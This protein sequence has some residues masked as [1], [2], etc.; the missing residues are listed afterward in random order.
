MAKW[1]VDRNS[2]PGSVHDKSNNDDKATVLQSGPWAAAIQEA[3]SYAFVVD[4][5]CCDRDVDSNKSAGVSRRSHRKKNNLALATPLER[6]DCS[7][8]YLDS[9]R[10]LL[11]QQDNWEW[12]PYPC[13]PPSFHPLQ[14][15]IIDDQNT[16]FSASFNKEN[17]EDA[18]HNS[19]QKITFHSSKSSPH[20][21]QKTK[22]SV[23][24][25]NLSLSQGNN[26]AY[27]RNRFAGF[28]SDS[29]SDRDEGDDPVE[30]LEPLNTLMDQD[31]S[32]EAN[33]YEPSHDQEHQQ[34]QPLETMDTI[35]LLI[36]LKA[37]Q[38]D[39]YAKKARLMATARYWLPGAEALHSSSVV[40]TQ[41]LELADATISKTL[42]L[43]TST[44]TSTVGSKNKKKNDVR[45]RQLERDADII[46]VSTSY[47]IYEKERYLKVAHS[48]ALKLEHI[49][50]PMWERR[51]QARQRMGQ[52]WNKNPNP[53]GYF[54][55]M[56]KQYEMELYALEQALKSLEE[57]QANASS[58]M[59]EAGRL[60]NKLREIKYAQNRHNGKKRRSRPNNPAEAIED[61]LPV[62]YMWAFTGSIDSGEDS[63]EFYEKW[64]DS[65]SPSLTRGA[66]AEITTGGI[67][68]PSIGNKV[69][70]TDTHGVEN[71]GVGTEQ[72]KT[73]GHLVLVQLDVHATT[74]AIRTVVEYPA[75]YDDDSGTLIQPTWKMELFYSST[76]I[77]LELYRRVLTDP[78]SVRNGDGNKTMEETPNDPDGKENK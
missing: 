71:S 63:V 77:D 45:L 57:S 10:V 69:E 65:G 74:G 61:N 56:R 73:C 67:G 52:R 9:L 16:T 47:L 70:P 20:K 24:S 27:S 49:L 2:N 46:S 75:D 18:S 66:T 23:T 29:D 26:W 68:P 3:T 35:R 6:V 5:P 14:E 54:A 11:E 30:D 32:A 21:N 4:D 41:G 60:R 37:S 72:H 17:K 50:R 1:T 22:H 55:R 28:A 53:S 36:R 7:L 40:L 25:G 38:S 34:Q 8:K 58:L 62:Q 13:N 42:S 48:Q 51:D 64:V 43:A 44:S 76:S 15:N 12:V 78:M 31:L 33:S 59:D 19:P 39:L